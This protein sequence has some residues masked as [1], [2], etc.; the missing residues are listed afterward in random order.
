MSSVMS[1]PVIKASPVPGAQ[2]AKPEVNRVGPAQLTT[3]ESPGIQLS[4]V[5]RRYP[6]ACTDC[7][8][9]EEAEGLAVLTKIVFGILIGAILGAILTVAIAT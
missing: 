1:E 2:T 9:A 3:L 8:K 6:I 4:A 7:A 5:E